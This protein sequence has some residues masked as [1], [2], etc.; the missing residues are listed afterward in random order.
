MI[1]KS[2]YVNYQPTITYNPQLQIDS[3]G[4][5][6]GGSTVTPSITVIPSHTQNTNQS[7]TATATPDMGISGGGTG[8]T[9]L[10]IVGGALIAGVLILPSIVKGFSKTRRVKRGK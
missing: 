10:L 3:P 4:G 5:Q 9:D 6:I 8:I 7:D 1:D 2:K